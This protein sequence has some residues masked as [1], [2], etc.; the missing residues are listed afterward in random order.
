MAYTPLKPVSLKH[1]G[2]DGMPD[3]D[4]KGRWDRANGAH[5]DLIVLKC[6]GCSYLKVM[7]QIF[8]I[9]NHVGAV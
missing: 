1:D 2:T 3:T 9:T 8:L 5:E 7:L 6:Y 4:G